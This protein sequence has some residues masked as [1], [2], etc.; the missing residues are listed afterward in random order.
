MLLQMHPEEQSLFGAQS[1][2]IRMRD[3][4]GKGSSRWY[5]PRSRRIFFVAE[6]HRKLLLLVAQ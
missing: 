2:D 3:A 6:E 4:K 5:R 1:F